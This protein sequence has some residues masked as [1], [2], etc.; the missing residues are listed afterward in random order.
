MAKR[1]KRFGVIFLLILVVAYFGISY[2]FSGMI[3]QPAPFSME[4]TKNRIKTA[5][6][7][8]FEA[9]NAELPV[10]ELF[11]VQSDD[12]LTLQGRYY[13]KSDSADCAVILIHGW[14]SN[15]AGMLKYKDIFWECGC[16]LAFYDH[17]GHNDSQGKYGTGGVLEKADLLR[18]TDWVT[19]NKGFSLDQIGW[20]GASWGAATALQ[21]GADSKNVAF[22]IA[23]AP[24]QDWYTAIFERADRWYGSWTRVLA[25]TVMGFVNFRAGINTKDASVLKYIDQVEEPVFLIHSQTDEATSSFQSINIAE[26][27]KPQNSVFYHTDWGA[28]HTMD[29][30]KRPDVY[31]DL[32]YDFLQKY[33]PDFADCATN[34]ID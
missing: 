7:S 32:V 8:S 19:A 2:F 21:A 18:V 31:K 22:I 23:D 11:S 16:D 6:N 5:W 15:W 1:L 29:V 13:T 12:D 30:I 4:R 33:R 24:F 34:T 14:G 28:G 26:K 27:L 17:R 25:P 3:L 10:P 20:F 9:E